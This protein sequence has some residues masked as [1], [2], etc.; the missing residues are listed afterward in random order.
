VRSKPNSIKPISDLAQA[1]EALAEIAGIKREI[2]EIELNM[3]AAIDQVK[4]EGE[5][6]AAP[7]QA[8]I[9]A[10]EGGL[11]AYAEFNKKSLFAERRSKDLDHG[12]IGYR[13]SS[14]IKPKTRHTWEMVLGLLKDMKFASAVRTKEEVNREELATWPNE[15]LE[16]VGARR[17]EK[18]AFWYEIRQETITEKA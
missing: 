11:Q 17:V 3:N 12:S 5:A 1:N 16:L 8:R 13:K 4:A 9:K 7:L 10:I 15:R 6:A 18:D 2:S 14:Q